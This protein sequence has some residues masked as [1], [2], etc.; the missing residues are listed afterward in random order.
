MNGEDA[1]ICLATLTA[2]AFAYVPKPQINMTNFMF[3]TMQKNF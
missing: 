1:L 2:E 3:K